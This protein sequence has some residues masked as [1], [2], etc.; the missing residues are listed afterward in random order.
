MEAHYLTE[1]FC[2]DREITANYLGN[3]RSFKNISAYS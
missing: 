1:I 2:L 3:K